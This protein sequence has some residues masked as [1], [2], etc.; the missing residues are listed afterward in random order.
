VSPPSTELRRLIN[1]YQV[2]QAIHVAAALGIADLLAGGPRDSDDLAAATKSDARALYR[3]LR[4]LAAVGVLRE[5]EGRRFSLTSLGDGLRS[6]SE[7]PVG[8]WA[9]F[10]GRPSYWRAW[11]ALLHSVRTGENAFRHVNDADVWTYR[12]AHPEEAAI[13]DRAMADLTLRSHASVMQAYDFGSFGTVVDVGG[14][15]G[16]F[17]AALLPAHPGMR[18]ILLD[19]PN[20]VAAA[21]A[22]FAAAGVADRCEAVAGDFFAAVPEGGDAYVLRAVLHD[23]EDEEAAAILATCRRA[24]RPDSAVVIIERD[25]GPSNAKPDAKL[26]DLNMLVAPGGR[27]RSVAEYGDLLAGAGL[28]LAE[29]HE[30]GYGLHVM[31]GVVG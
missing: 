22:V 29:S 26:S 17:L 15:Q 4:A 1:G 18:G 12:A 27:E 8:G 21:A 6:D 2:S 5:E 23:W 7:A 28:S 9:A 10:I 13:F 30:A 14:G 19:L 3:L 31:V 20:A 25:L 16:A 11:G 24:M